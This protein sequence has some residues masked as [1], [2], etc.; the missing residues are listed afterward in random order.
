[1]INVFKLG[2]A[3]KTESGLEYTVKPI[4]NRDKDGWHRTLDLADC[5]EADFKVNVE[6]ADCIEVE[7]VKPKKAKAKK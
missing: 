7:T 3:W 2:G 1:M 4:N 5:I 6:D